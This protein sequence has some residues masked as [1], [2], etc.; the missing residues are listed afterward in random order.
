[1][2][3]GIPDWSPESWFWECPKNVRQSNIWYADRFTPTVCGEHAQHPNWR[4]VIG[5]HPHRMWGTHFPARS[6]A[7]FSTDSDRKPCTVRGET[8][9]GVVILVPERRNA[10]TPGGMA[11]C[12]G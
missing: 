12:D 4:N 7:A 1:M 3:T 8:V 5:V 6:D 9:P 2:S 10:I 11:W